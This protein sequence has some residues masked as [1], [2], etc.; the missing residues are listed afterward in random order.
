[1]FRQIIRFLK[2]VFQSKGFRIA[3]KVILW[4]LMASYLFIYYRVVS[5]LMRNG[6][7]FRESV[8]LIFDAIFSPLP[9]TFLSIAVGIVIGIFGFYRGRT[10]KTA[11][12]AEDKPA[13]TPEPVPAQEEAFT[14]TK[15]YM[16]R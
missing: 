5:H 12:E 6:F 2:R 1:M 7:S 10:K 9:R 13:E 15:H 16:S 14:E 4:I 8:S 3:A 11:S